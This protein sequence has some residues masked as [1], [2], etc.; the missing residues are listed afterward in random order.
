MV[1][2]FVFRGIIEEVGTVGHIAPLPEKPE[3]Y[4]FRVQS[5]QVIQKIAPGDSI[6]VNGVCLTVVDIARQEIVFHLWPG[7]Q[8]NTNLLSLKPGDCVNL[9]TNRIHSSKQLECEMA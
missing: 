2:K 4:A 6:A 9:E 3:L 5:H 1:Q 8:N 7:T